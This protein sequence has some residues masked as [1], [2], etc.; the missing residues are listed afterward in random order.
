M[1]VRMR[2]Q[3]V[4]DDGTVLTDDT[5][6]ELDKPTLQLEALGL[7]LA[8]AKRLLRAT[9]E[10]LLVV[11]HRLEQLIDTLALRAVLDGGR[12]AARSV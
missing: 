5:V 12:S 10:R 7:S 2:M 11:R 1:N 3:I 6:L 4:D 9:Q 8:E